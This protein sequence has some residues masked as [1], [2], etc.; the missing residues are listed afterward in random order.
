[1]M[2]I[3]IIALTGVIINEINLI[4]LILVSCLL[5]ALQ[6]V[7][8]IY[9]LNSK[10]DSVNRTRCVT[11][12]TQCNSTDEESRSNRL[13][14]NPF[15]AFIST[16]TTTFFIAGSF[17]KINS[18]SSMLGIIAISGLCIVSGLFI[19]NLTLRNKPCLQ[20]FS[21]H[22]LYILLFFGVSLSFIQHVKT[23]LVDIQ[24]NPGQSVVLV[25]IASI[26]F[27]LNY[28]LINLVANKKKRM[29]KQKRMDIINNN[30]N[31]IPKQIAS[32]FIQALFH[33]NTYSGPKSK[34]INDYILIF[35]DHD[36]ALCYSE[37]IELYYNYQFQNSEE[38]TLLVPVFSDV[39]ALNLI[40][41]YNELRIE[42]SD[43]KLM[44]NKLNK[45]ISDENQSSI[46]VTEEVEK[47][48]VSVNL[49]INYTSLNSFPFVLNRGFASLW[50]FIVR[51]NFP[52]LIKKALGL[53]R[54]FPFLFLNLAIMLF[55]RI[56]IAKD[57]NPNKYAGLIY[58]HIDLYAAIK[59]P[60]ANS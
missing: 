59:R 21:Q 30:L 7:N 60:Y 24:I 17:T 27:A 3:L 25:G 16:L 33:L 23:G 39:T 14:L 42:I 56:F 48:I 8:Q 40:Q 1:M 41:I 29:S 10:I 57:Y 50:D 55:I 31:K 12:A 2:A 9:W 28:M 46:S 19:Y 38:K 13:D 43:R 35:Y 18:I 22:F 58:W 52:T 5:T 32:D 11:I 20:C 54:Q 36:C 37:A 45:E 47:Y 6:V 49:F 53:N 44:T 15:S 26:L 4:Y 34:S 51:S